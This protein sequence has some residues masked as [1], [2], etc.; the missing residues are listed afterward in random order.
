MSNNGINLGRVMAIVNQGAQAARQ[1]DLE[2]AKAGVEKQTQ[3]RKEVKAKLKMLKNSDASLE[4][5]A[6]GNTGLF[7]GFIDD[8]I[9]GLFGFRDESK[10]VPKE[11]AKNAQARKSAQQLDVDAEE[12]LSNLQQDIRDVSESFEDSNGVVNDIQSELAKI[13]QVS[14]DLG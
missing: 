5:M 10:Y 1:D 12:Q 2:D 7:K 11:L 4:E 3:V 8:K 6:E 14:F 13:D 9:G